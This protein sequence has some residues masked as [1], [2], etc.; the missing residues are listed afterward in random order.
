MLEWGSSKPCIWTWVVAE[1]ISLTALLTHEVGSAL[2]CCPCDKASSP[3]CRHIWRR[4][5]GQLR[6]QYG[7]PSPGMSPWPVVVTWA[8]DINKDLC[9][10]RATDLDMALGNSMGRVIT[11]AQAVTSDHSSV[12]CCCSISSSASLHSAQSTQLLFLSHLP[13]T[14]L[15]SL[16]VLSF[17]PFC[18]SV[19]FPALQLYF[20]LPV[21][22]FIYLALFFSSWLL[23][24]FHLLL[25]QL[26][27]RVFSFWASS[28]VVFLIPFPQWLV[29]PWSTIVHSMSCISCGSLSCISWCFLHS[30]SLP[31][32]V[33]MGDVNVTTKHSITV[34]LLTKGEI[35]KP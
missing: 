12:M 13:T 34:P 6:Y 30:L 16:A 5:K 35:T 25:P 23:H 21:S 17:L 11:M 32:L 9:C 28:T 20:P 8:M 10:G 2:H 1:F 18:Q 15:F 33:V 7:Q 27:Y 24:L 26:P 19:T 29:T 14:Y 4:G 3:E 22:G 31:C